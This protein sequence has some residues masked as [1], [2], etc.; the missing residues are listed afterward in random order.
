MQINFSSF[1]A[2][3]PLPSPE[4]EGEGGGGGGKGERG[5][6][7]QLRFIRGGSVPSFN[8][9]A[10]CIPFFDKNGTSFLYLLLIN[11]T[12]FTCPV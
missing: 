6:A 1:L 9:L 5:G 7:T 11:A 8:P 4:G 2:A 10:F 3:S 12:S